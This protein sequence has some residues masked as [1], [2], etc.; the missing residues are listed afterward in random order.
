MSKVCPKCGYKD[1][2]A[3]TC[4]DCYYN[5]KI[6]VKTVDDVNYVKKPLFKGKDFWRGSAGS[7]IASKV[8]GEV[9]SE[10]KGFVDN[11]KEDLKMRY[12]DKKAELVYRYKNKKEELMSAYEGKKAEVKESYAQKKEAVKQVVNEKI[13]PGVKRF[14]EGVLGG[15]LSDYVKTQ[16]GAYKVLNASRLKKEASDII[17]SLAKASG[18]M[19]NENFNDAEKVISDSKKALVNVRGRI[20][21]D[22]GSGVIF[23]TFIKSSDFE[24]KARELELKISESR[25]ALRARKEVGLT[26][27]P[28]NNWQEFNYCSKCGGKYT[29]DVD[30]FCA[31]CGKKRE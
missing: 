28:K 24:S 11:K 21:N 2:S 6:V 30:K 13:I 7:V 26:S 14:D 10:V 20:S 29:G 3:E 15:G 1:L 27:E 19:A 17:D 4:P 5:K 9:S 12:Q 25:L 31:Y 18:L 8:K 16:S 23:E 22:S